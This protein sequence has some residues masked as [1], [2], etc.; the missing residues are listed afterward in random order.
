[1]K[2][3]NIPNS[4]LPSDYKT[5]FSGF[6]IRR[7]DAID[8]DL[9]AYEVDMGGSPE[10]RRSCNDRLKQ[11]VS[12]FLGVR[13][14]RPDK[15]YEVE[16]NDRIHG[17]FGLSELDCI[18]ANWSLTPPPFRVW[19]Q[20]KTFYGFADICRS[21]HGIIVPALVCPTDC[22]SMEQIETP[23]VFFEMLGAVLDSGSCALRH[24]LEPYD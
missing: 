10:L 7:P 15:M 22:R 21:K 3:T 12:R 24:R 23:Y 14:D 2:I 16:P 1:M 6:S 9:V 19:A 5:I 11:L 8:F 18:A 13:A 17:Y 20:D 4:V